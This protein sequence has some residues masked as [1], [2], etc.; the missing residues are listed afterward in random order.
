MR[1]LLAAAT[2]LTFGA[3]TAAFADDP[4]MPWAWGF[5]TPPPATMP[6]PAP[7]APPAALD[8]TTPHT[9]TGS[10]LK[11]T[12]AQIAKPFRAGGRLVPGR[13]P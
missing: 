6:P 1:K 9:L 3:A 11:F 4:P 10:Q 8:N 5:T 2:V 13:S 7:P 12:R